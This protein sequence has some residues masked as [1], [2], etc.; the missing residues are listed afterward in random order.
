MLLNLAISLTPPGLV[1]A[2]LL[3]AG[4]VVGDNWQLLAFACSLGAM[5]ADLRSQVKGNRAQLERIDRDG[6][7]H[8]QRHTLK[9]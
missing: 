4:D 3:A 1:A 7:R 9:E 2:A 5:W 6:C 8:L